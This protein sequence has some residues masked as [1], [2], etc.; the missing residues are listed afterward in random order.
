[1]LGLPVATHGAVMHPAY[2]AV[3]QLVWPIPLEGTQSKLNVEKVFA[4]GIRVPL[5]TAAQTGAEFV[6]VHPLPSSP[7]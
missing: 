1:M 3:S 7:H 2:G 5:L 6:A 4:F